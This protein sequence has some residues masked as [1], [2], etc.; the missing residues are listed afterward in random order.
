M[1]RIILLLILIIIIAGGLY[2][3]REY[4]RK[5]KDLS[6]TEAAT[7]TD[8]LTLI[9][10]FEKD[11]SS[12]NKQFLDKV[13]AVTGTIKKVESEENPVIIFLGDETQMS[14]VQCSMDSAYSKGHASLKKGTTVTVKGIVTGVQ[15]DELL[16]TD[17]KLNRC[18][19]EEKK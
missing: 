14:S 7:T 8:A 6:S 17:V 2:A 11:S 3:Y 4:N 10:T 5:N 13:V 1:K 12:A 9:T 16:G 18:V 19:I 15:S